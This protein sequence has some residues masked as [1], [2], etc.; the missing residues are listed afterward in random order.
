MAYVTAV[1]SQ[2]GG[3]GKTT[4]AANLAAALAAEGQN[5]LLLE[6]DPQGALIPSLGLAPED[7][8]H[9]L[10]DV[11]EDRT[12]PRDAVVPTPFENLSLLAACLPGQDEL[13]LEECAAR[14][15]MH[16]REVVDKL[17]PHFDTILL[18]GPPTLGHLAR[19][20]LSA[21][22]GF[23]VPVQA[24][25]MS[26]RT[27]ERFF[28]VADAVS[29]DYNPELRCDGILITMADLRTR[30]AV[31]VVNQLHEHYGDKLLINM[32][33]RTV[34]LQEMPDRGKPAML[35]APSSRGAQAYREV[36]N[37]LL[38][39]RGGGRDDQ[40]GDEDPMDL[41][42]SLMDDLNDA[43]PA[44]LAEVLRPQAVDRATGPMATS[45]ALERNPA[46]FLTHLGWDEPESSPRRPA[47]DDASLQ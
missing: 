12:A 13:G 24:E 43:D 37:E 3:V 34:S 10:I 7:L 18:D 40:S 31:K 47:G 45:D 5:V 44:V 16:L 4:T 41:S 26:Y 2:K 39:Q 21:A 25:E 19:M 15:P 32:V 30:M 6:V 35:Y 29:A 1:V 28:S 20:T 33:P 42:D 27:L 17:V 14:H 22:D 23:L 9:S 11:L 46:L 38:S 8:T 36:A